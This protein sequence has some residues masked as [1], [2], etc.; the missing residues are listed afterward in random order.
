MTFAFVIAIF[1]LIFYLMSMDIFLDA[2]ESFQYIKI[3]NLRVPCLVTSFTLI[4][5]SF[6]QNKT[7]IL[8][9][10]TYNQFREDCMTNEANYLEIE[11]NVP[12]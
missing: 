2:A 6:A 4:M 11:R 12:S 10:T 8:P 3:V 9:D 7:Q 1:F 5:E